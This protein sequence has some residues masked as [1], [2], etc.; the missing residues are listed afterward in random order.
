MVTQ[1]N[2]L[3]KMVPQTLGEKCSNTGKYRPEKTPSLGTFHAVKIRLSLKVLGNIGIV[4]TENCI[5]NRWS[6][7]EIYTTQK[8][9]KSLT[10]NFIFCAVIIL[11]S[12]C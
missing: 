12:N 9:K 7:S 2:S 4:K 8:M 11:H 10:E 3:P 5:L 1:R 6:I